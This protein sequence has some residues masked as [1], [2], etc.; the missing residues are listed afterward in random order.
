[1]TFFILGICNFKHVRKGV[2]VEP[3]VLPCQ[4]QGHYSN[5][6]SEFLQNFSMNFLK[7]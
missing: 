6:L 2:E 1:M 5:R 7:R 3:V 4:Q